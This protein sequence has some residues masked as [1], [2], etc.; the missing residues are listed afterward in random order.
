[1]RNDHRYNPLNNICQQQIR[2]EIV[3]VEHVASVQDENSATI[4]FAAYL[5]WIIK[6]FEHLLWND[7]SF[8]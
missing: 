3:H 2:K 1:M 8:L 4:L 7:S 6:I 5:R